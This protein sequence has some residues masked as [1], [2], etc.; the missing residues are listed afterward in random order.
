CG[1]AQMARAGENYGSFLVVKRA[2]AFAALGHNRRGGDL[3]QRHAPFFTDRPQ[4]MEI[5][6]IADR[7]DGE[8]FRFHASILYMLKNW[9]DGVLEY[10]SIGFQVSSLPELLFGFCLI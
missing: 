4:T 2:H 9:S 7:I 8:F 6:F 10:W 5:H 3:L 1:Q